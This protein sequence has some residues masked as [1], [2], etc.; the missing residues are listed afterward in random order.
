MKKTNNGEIILDPQPEESAND[1]L[2]WPTWHRDAAL[3]SLGFYCMVG[4]GIGSIL[5][6]GFPMSA[7]TTASRS[8]RWPSQRFVFFIG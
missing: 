1:P 5:T 6:A 2:N 4:R 7:T 8:R 3:L